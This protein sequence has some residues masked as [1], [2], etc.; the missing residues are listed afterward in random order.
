MYYNVIMLEHMLC[1]IKQLTTRGIT[2]YI[3]V[4][5]F[6]MAILCIILPAFNLSLTSAKAEKCPKEKKQN[7][8]LPMPQEP[9]HNT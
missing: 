3:F 8:R 5:Y 4:F 9:N 6:N 1:K 2:L 7:G